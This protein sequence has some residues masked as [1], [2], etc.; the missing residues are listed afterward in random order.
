M[1]ALNGE[2]MIV[3]KKI[4]RKNIF[5]ISGHDMYPKLCND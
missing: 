1:H 5:V 4:A 2:N 3:V